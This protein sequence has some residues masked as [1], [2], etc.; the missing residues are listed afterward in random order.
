MIGRHSPSHIELPHIKEDSSVTI[1]HGLQQQR[2]GNGNIFN[3]SSRSPFKLSSLLMDPYPQDQKPQVL[4][5]S[6][7][8]ANG[9]TT[10]NGLPPPNYSMNSGTIQH[11]SQG[12]AYSDPFAGSSRQQI[13]LHP[14][15]G[16][17]TQP[18]NI[19]G[20]FSHQQAYSAVDFHH[21]VP[22]RADESNMS[23]AVNTQYFPVSD[24]SRHFQTWPAREQFQGFNGQQQ[25]FLDPFHDPTVNIMDNQPGSS[26]PDKFDSSIP[27]RGQP[28]PRETAR[29]MSKTRIRKDRSSSA[30]YNASVSNTPEPLPRPLENG[31]PI[32]AQVLTSPNTALQQSYQYASNDNSAMYSPRDFGGNGF[33]L[34]NNLPLP[35][36]PLPPADMSY[37]NRNLPL[38][39]TSAP[40][41]GFYYRQPV[42]YPTTSS[43]YPQ[44]SRSPDSVRVVSTPPKPRCWDHGCDGRQFSTFSNLLRHQREKSGVASKSVCPYC[45]AE[46]T[47]STA[48]NGHMAH[49][50]CKKG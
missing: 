32:P 36:A 48:R 24:S 20:P 50:K 47:R 1:R 7:F 21:G 42:I 27:Y 41:L 31:L 9:S 26:S 12:Q 46:F 40:D 13:P 44:A 29:R 30:S 23:S 22:E 16:N 18:A 4:V 34:G 10:L 25:T 28:R 49:E 8:T 38:N 33:N 11:L 39:S 19:W 35:T 14:E 6:D 17:S 3:L 2:L 45:G 15:T 5:G 37:Q 43:Q